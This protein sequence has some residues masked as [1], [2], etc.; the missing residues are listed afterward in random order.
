MSIKY[1]YIEESDNENFIDSI[2]YNILI[3][4]DVHD[5]SIASVDCYLDGERKIYAN[6]LKN[7]F[8]TDK[9]NAIKYLL[10]KLEDYGYVIVSKEKILKIKAMT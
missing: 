6:T 3:I 4:K 2:I 7:K 9:N 1:C 8:Y 10:S 5:N